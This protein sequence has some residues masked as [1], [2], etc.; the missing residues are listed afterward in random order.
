MGNNDKLRVLAELADDVRELID[1]HVIQRSIYLVKY[2]EWRGLDQVERK[3]Q[4]YGCQC[5]FST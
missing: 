4:G 3:E 2:T 5:F 1:V